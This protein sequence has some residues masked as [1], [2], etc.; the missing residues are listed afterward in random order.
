MRVEDLLRRLH[1]RPITTD[2]LKKAVRHLSKADDVQ[3]FLARI[4]DTDQ[5]AEAA[6]L[7]RQRG[8]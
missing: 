4:P 3:P 6:S 2:R 5:R 7:I 1:S 8:L